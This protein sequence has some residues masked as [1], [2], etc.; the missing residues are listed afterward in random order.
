MRPPFRPEQRLEAGDIEAGAGAVD[1]PVEHLVHDRP[2]PEQQVAAVLD[3]V[4]GIVVAGA[5]G[6]LLG[7]VQ[8]EAQND[9]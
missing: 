1:D 9:V 2:I 5:G 3:L 8:G 4:D 7:L 6:V